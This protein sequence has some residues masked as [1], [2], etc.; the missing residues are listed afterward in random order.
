MATRIH[1]V[2]SGYMQKLI[3]LSRIMKE[4]RTL[5]HKQPFI[6][7][8]IRNILCCVLYPFFLLFRIKFLLVH[9]YNIGH[10]AIEPDCYLKERTLKA[11]DTNRPKI[12]LLSA[13]LNKVANSHLLRYWS[14]H[15]FVIKSPLICFFLFPLIKKKKTT[16]S[17]KKYVQDFKNLDFRRILFMKLR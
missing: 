5:R 8:W 13:P 11:N 16:Y 1:L 6:L 15:M 4:K 7:K 14:D 10:L 12:T 9:I 17:T 2:H 3:G